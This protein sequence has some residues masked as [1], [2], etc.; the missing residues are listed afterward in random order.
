LIAGAS[1]HSE[2]QA[3]QQLDPLEASVLFMNL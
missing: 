2:V 1:R 3:Q